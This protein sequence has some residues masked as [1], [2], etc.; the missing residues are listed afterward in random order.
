MNKETHLLFT[1]CT[2]NGNQKIF[3]FIEIGMDLCSKIALRHFNI[4]FGGTVLSHEIEEAFIDVNL[5]RI[6]A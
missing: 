1:H 5:E 2:N 4:V 3:A 6:S